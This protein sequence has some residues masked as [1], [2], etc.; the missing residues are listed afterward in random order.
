M[1]F[2]KQIV[3]LQILNEIKSFQFF[4]EKKIIQYLFVNLDLNT[5]TGETK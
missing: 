4:I 1:K 3:L 5:K 2:Y